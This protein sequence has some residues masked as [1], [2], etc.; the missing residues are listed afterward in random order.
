MFIRLNVYGKAMSVERKQGEWLLYSESPTSMRVRVYDIVIPSDLHEFELG[1][2]LAD[3][4][5]EQASDQHPT[6]EYQK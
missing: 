6:V 3:I 2:Y 5:H 1:Q 4:Y